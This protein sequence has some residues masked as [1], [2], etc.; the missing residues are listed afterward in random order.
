L[1]EGTIE[2][3]NRWK[4]AAFVLTLICAFL[5]GWEIAGWTAPQPQQAL[6]PPTTVTSPPT[7][8]PT[9]TPTDTPTPTPSPTATATPTRTPTPRPTIDPSTLIYDLYLPLI[10]HAEP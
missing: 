7:A 2:T 5:I 3:P 6:S 1:K 4:Q 9:S 8:S 10:F